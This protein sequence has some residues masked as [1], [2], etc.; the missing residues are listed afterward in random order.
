MPWLGADLQTLRNTVRGP[1]IAIPPQPVRR[2]MLP[3][4]DGSGDVLA[5]AWEGDAAGELPLA[6]LIHGL[7][8]CE[9]S[10]YLRTSAA[11]LRGRG[12]AVV[13]LNLRGAGA[14]RPT[15]R[16]QYHAGRTQDLADA[17][18]GL[19]ERHGAAS[20]FL[21]GY[22][23]GGN[24]LLK[25]LGEHGHAY[26]I[27]GAVSVSAP[28]DLEAACRRILEPRNR[29]YHRSLLTRMRVEALEE[30]AALA[31]EER[32][33]VE[34]SRTILQFDEEFVAP[35]NG[36]A[37]AREYYEANGSRR[38]LPNIGIPTLV[39]HSLD[40]PWIPPDSYR[41]F[42]WAANPRLTP[43]LSERGGHVGFHGAEARVPWHD[44]CIGVF[45]EQRLQANRVCVA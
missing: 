3:M 36:Y 33:A 23:L 29:V 43:L 6:V 28:L 4:R 42:D 11:V 17:L 24:M 31:P 32:R 2:V 8:G 9:E 35:R 5:G 14:S 12:L 20:F 39:I 25:F 19:L 38:F 10:D 27:V 18:T 15:C 30:G 34:S 13:R 45:L 26:P 44:R 1:A 21:V 16:L 40:D 37:G 22:S 7:G 41:C